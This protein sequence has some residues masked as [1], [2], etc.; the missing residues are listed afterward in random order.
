MSLLSGR[1]HSQTPWTTHNASG[2]MTC[3]TLDHATGKCWS[4]A[5]NAAAP[6]IASYQWSKGLDGVQRHNVFLYM[7][8]KVP[9][10]F[11]DE[12]DPATGKPQLD[13]E[14]S[15]SDAQGRR[16]RISIDMRTGKASTQFRRGPSAAARCARQS[17]RRPRAECFHR[18]Q[19]CGS[20]PHQPERAKIEA[21]L[22]LLRFALWPDNK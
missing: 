3:Q 13:S 11:S 8:N 15:L 22:R 1:L 5:Q 20:S 10:H 6:S 18:H 14:W 17:T 2:L 21:G 7:P 16:S 9:L 12:M 4:W 19:W